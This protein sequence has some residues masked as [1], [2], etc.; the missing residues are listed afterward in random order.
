MLTISKLFTILCI[1]WLCGR[2]T[3]LD[4]KK[5]ALFQTSA[6]VYYVPGPSRFYLSSKLSLTCG[7]G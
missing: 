1:L 2:N 5:I 6:Q 4:L 7:W 3:M